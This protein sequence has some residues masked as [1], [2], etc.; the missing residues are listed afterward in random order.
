MHLGMQRTSE[1]PQ[2]A[3]L[4]ENLNLQRALLRRLSNAPGI[5]L[6]DVAKVAS[7]T[8]DTKERGH[9]PLVHLSN[10]KTLRARLLVS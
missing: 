10:G 8:R 6:L 9:W 4:T 7:I 1:S 2:M 3:R 5:Q